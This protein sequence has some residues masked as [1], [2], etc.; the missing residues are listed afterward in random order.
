MEA[1]CRKKLF[2][3]ITA[4]LQIGLFVYAATSKLTDLENFT[5]QIGQSPMLSAFAGILAIAVP[6]AELLIS[7]IIAIPRTRLIGLY[8]AFCLMVMFS[9]YIFIILNYGSFVP[10]SCGGIL[11][12]MGW[13]EHL[14]FNIFFVLILVTSI[15]LDLK[16]KN[17]IITR[18]PIRLG[19]RLGGL[20]FMNVIAVGGLYFLSEGIIH[21][22]NNFVRRF[23]KF[24]EPESRKY[25][26][27]SKAFYFAGAAGNIIY[28]GNTQA[29]RMVIAIDT[30]F[31]SV[32]KIVIKMDNMDLP[33]VSVQVRVDPP[34]FYLT[35]GTV[36]CIFKGNI[37]DW[38]ARQITTPK[39]YFSS[40]EPITEGRMV[41]K[42]IN[43]QSVRSVIGLLDVKS[44]K[45]IVWNNNLL[46]SQGDGIF[47]VDGQL[48]RNGLTGT[49]HYIHFYRNEFF[50]ADSSLRLLHRGHTIDTVSKSNLKV[51]YLRQRGE[52]KLSAPALLV[53]KTAFICLKVRLR[54]SP[55]LS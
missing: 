13:K 2:I 15:I 19:L 47:D 49:L 41:I 29:P 36:P 35:D 38:K 17:P 23:P 44:G 54:M 48:F 51:A 9:A 39:T 21:H 24:S 4:L 3:E 28:L 26:L 46:V 43:P 11:E 55:L 5:V 22:R 6:I 42:T 1:Y 33:F 50:A 7:V 45:P 27:K 30:A 12:K 53:N 20:F 52:R 32:K 37:N 8:L 34:Y 10:C 40:A 18:R 31:K 25:D 14:V 16:L